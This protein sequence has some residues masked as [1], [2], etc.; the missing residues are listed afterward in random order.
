MAERVRERRP[1]N[2]AAS[3]RALQAER[4]QEAA[5]P[6]NVPV[7]CQVQFSV[8][9]RS[10]ARHFVAEARKFCPQD[11][12]SA[13]G[14]A[15]LPSLTPI[16]CGSVHG[17][18]PDLYICF[19]SYRLNVVARTLTLMPSRTWTRVTLLKEYNGTEEMIMFEGDR[20]TAGNRWPLVRVTPGHATEVTLLSSEFFA[21]STHWAKVTV[22]CAG[23]AC[24]LCN[25]C[26]TRGLFYLAVTWCSRL[27][28][29]EL[30]GQGAN[31]LEQHCKLLHGDLRPGLVLRLGR[32]RQKDPVRS[33]CVRE[34]P[35][36]QPVPLLA[37]ARHVMAVYKFPPPNPSEAI[38]DYERRC[39]SVAQI[40][41]RA[42]A[43]QLTRPSQMRG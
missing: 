29:L 32:K 17:F 40:R 33:E 28:L 11:M 3:P 26:A 41:N 18:S 16:S 31:D 37:L 25:V 6:D 36:A 42:L 12:D 10:V 24:D 9:L 27:S 14:N 39:R 1:L 43:A 2:R 20:G 8:F 5:E 23:E 35:A 38:E 21:I 7:R 22:P 19:L 13:G 4:R 15:S 30:G 34:I